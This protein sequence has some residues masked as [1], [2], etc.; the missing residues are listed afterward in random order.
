MTCADRELWMLETRQRCNL[1]NGLLRARGTAILLSIQD[2]CSRYRA[3]NVKHF[4][5]EGIFH[6]KKPIQVVPQMN[7]THLSC[8]HMTVGRML[9]YLK[10]GGHCV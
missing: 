8:S 2:V 6:K 5:R 3:R 7:I 4:E 1:V 10:G 9:F